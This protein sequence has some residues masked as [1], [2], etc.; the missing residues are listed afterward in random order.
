MNPVMQK[1]AWDIMGYL[2][3]LSSSSGSGGL[4]HLALD[5]Q[6]IARI[7]EVWCQ[8]IQGAGTA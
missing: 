5:C 4:L 7:T 1:I 8:L 2:G 3:T 6:A